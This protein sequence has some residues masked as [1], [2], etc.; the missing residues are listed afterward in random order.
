MPNDVGGA[1]GATSNV[2]MIE[3]NATVI[4]ALLVEAR[5]LAESR[6]VQSL[7]ASRDIMV[8]LVRVLETLSTGGAPTTEPGSRHHQ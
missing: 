6:S 4:T 7:E 2:R 5:A 8:L 1:E 3:V